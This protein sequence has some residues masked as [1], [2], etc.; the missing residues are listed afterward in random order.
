MLTVNITESSPEALAVAEAEAHRRGVP[1]DEAFIPAHAPPPA[2]AG[3]PERW[4]VRGIQL[5]CSHCTKDLF[6]SRGVLLNTRGLTFLGLDWLN[7]SAH[8]MECAHCSLVQIFTDS[9]S[10]TQYDGGARV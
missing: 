4:F 5:N 8:A 10:R 9:P 7:Q 1:I 2:P 6:R 3:A